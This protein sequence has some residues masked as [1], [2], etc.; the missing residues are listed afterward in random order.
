MAKNTTKYVFRKLHEF[1]YLT[2]Q[3]V[4]DIGSGTLIPQYSNE[5]DDETFVFEVTAEMDLNMFKSFCDNHQLIAFVVTTN[6][7]IRSVGY[8]PE[9]TEDKKDDKWSHE[10]N[11]ILGAIYTY[12]LNKQSVKCAKILTKEGAEILLEMTN[13]DKKSG[14][15]EGSLF[16]TELCTSVVITSIK[17]IFLVRHDEEEEE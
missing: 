3:S 10:I 12:N 15:L 9:C 8:R 7:I 6:P 17:R 16:G 4:V 13:F 1:Q 5:L 2:I 11:H 14:V